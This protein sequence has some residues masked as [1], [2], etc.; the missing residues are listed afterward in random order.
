[1]HKFVNSVSVASCETNL[2]CKATRLAALKQTI[3]SK[4]SFVVGKYYII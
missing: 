2:L 1:M 4:I 3:L